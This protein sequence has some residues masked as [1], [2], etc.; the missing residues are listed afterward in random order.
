M[1]KPRMICPRC[2]AEMNHHATKIEYGMDDDTD[3]DPVFGGVLQ[4]ARTCPHCGRTE[5]R[6]AASFCNRASARGRRFNQ[7]RKENAGEELVE[8][9]HTR[10]PAYHP[11]DLKRLAAETDS[12]LSLTSKFV[13]SNS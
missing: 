8:H 9:R 1:S 2:G 6:P 4:E 5:L 12:F 13:S 10:E 3:V 7:H 11:A